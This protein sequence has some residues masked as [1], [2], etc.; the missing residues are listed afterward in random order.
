MFTAFFT[1]AI[2]VLAVAK[3]NSQ[4]CPAEGTLATGGAQKVARI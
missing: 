4:V 1:L 3:V 2:R